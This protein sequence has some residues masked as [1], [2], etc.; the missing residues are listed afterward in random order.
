MERLTRAKDEY[1]CRIKECSIDDYINNLMGEYPW[2][3]CDCCPFKKFINTLAEYED[4]EEE[5][6]VNRV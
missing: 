2:N 4:L 1:A 5:G 3:P 6:K